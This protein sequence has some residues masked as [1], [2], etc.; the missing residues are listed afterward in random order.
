MLVEPQRIDA[1][2]HQLVHQVLNRL[3]LRRRQIRHT[4][5]ERHDQRAHLRRRGS[6]GGGPAGFVPARY[7]RR[8]EVERLIKRSKISRAVAA[9][10][11]KSAY[12]FHGTVAF[13]AIPLWL[14]T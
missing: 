5:P 2:D 10:F 3:Y 8:N 1:I 4:L 6:N 9:C 7:A 14:R 12:A 11:D 13:A